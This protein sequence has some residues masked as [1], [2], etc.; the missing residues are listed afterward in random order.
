[1]PSPWNETMPADS[2]WRSETGMTPVARANEQDAAAGGRTARELLL[3]GGRIALA[4]IALR[5]YRRSRRIRAYL[6]WSDVGRTS[7]I[8]LGEVSRETRAENLR[9]GWEIVHARNLTNSQT[10]ISE[11]SGQIE[12]K[13]WASSQAVRNIMRANRNKDTK[14]E[15]LLRSSLHAMGM[16]YRV[17]YRPIP[18]LRRTADI[19]FTKARVAVFV[20]GCFWHGCPA[21]YR[22]S[23]KNSEFWR[24]KIEDN[25]ARDAETTALMSAAGWSVIRIWEHEPV[26][27]AAQRIFDA[28]HERA[29]I[30]LDSPPPP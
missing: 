7:E 9:Q 25:R 27:D 4:S 3:T 16:R 17:A 1:M 14:P 30:R 8:Y 29:A 18:T 13:S 23:T 24:A 2:A 20:D 28:V 26:A 21:H 15:I 6:R 12:G 10:V 19:V 11:S 22:P 5:L